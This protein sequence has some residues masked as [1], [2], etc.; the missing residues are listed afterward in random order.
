MK[1]FLNYIACILAL[2]SSCE[3]SLVEDNNIIIEQSVLNPGEIE[4]TIDLNHG[5]QLNKGVFG[6][7]S[8]LP[9][10]SYSYTTPGFIDRYIELVK[11]LIRFP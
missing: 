9:L 7:N 6:V 4:M 1:L 11:P 5:H 8:A 10:Q 3:K 2:F